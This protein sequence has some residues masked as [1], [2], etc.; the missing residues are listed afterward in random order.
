MASKSRKDLAKRAYLAGYDQ[1]IKDTSG[2]P[3]SFVSLN[4]VLSKFS[5]WWEKLPSKFKG[6]MN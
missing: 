1:A 3:A 6:L 4:K 5:G 2:K